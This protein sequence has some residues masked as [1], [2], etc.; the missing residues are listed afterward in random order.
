MKAHEH[1]PRRLDV[2]R[3]AG[4]GQQLAGQW[5]LS[6]MHRLAEAC[7]AEERPAPTDVVQ[8]Q[9]CAERRRVGGGESHAWL[10]LGLDTQL[11]LTCQRCLGPVD[12]P[13]QFEHWFHFVA[14][15]DQAAALDAD[16]EEDVL[17]STRALDLHQLAEDELLLALPLVPRHETCP[18]PL[19]VGPADVEDQDAVAPNPFA[20]LA[21]LKRRAH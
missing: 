9:A 14:G 11:K 19:P 5:P 4:A 1:D 18:H 6:G 10:K 8:W 20:V 12:T 7:H 17:A 3:F 13:L 2:E 16:A 15:E 21:G